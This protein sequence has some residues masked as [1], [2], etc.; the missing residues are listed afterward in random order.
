MATMIDILMPEDSQE[1]T[2]AN[3]G[4]W[5]AKVGDRV[6]QDDP[7]AE[8]ETD[9]VNVEVPAPAAGVLRE[10]LINEG[11]AVAPG[12]LLGRI[13]TGAAEPVSAPE[14]SPKSKP[15]PASAAAA[16]AA[17]AG[18]AERDASHLLSPSV[19][20][21]LAKHKLDRRLIKGTGRGGRI[22][23]RDAVQFLENKPAPVAAAAPSGAIP[24]RMVPH[25]KMR[26][27]IAAHMVES[28][29][30]TAPHVTAIF[31]MDLSSIIAH[32]KAHKA[33]FAKSGVNLTFTAYFVLASV[34]AIRAVP[35]VNSRFHADAL[36]IFDDMNIGVGTALGEKG[37]I[38]PVI[39]QAQRL[40]LFGVAEKLQ[41]LTQRAR[42]GKLAPREVQQGTFTISNH[43]VSGS[44]V[45][46]PIII[47]QPQSAILGVG[48]MQKRVIVVE[49]DG[50][51]SI[52]IRPMAY[53]TLSIDHR[54]LD[55]HQTNA[56]LSRFVA[57][58]EN[59]R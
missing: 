15:A 28:L 46:A 48:K 6:D 35:E 23:Y 25:D 40:N 50:Q 30:K 17:P 24:S 58:I 49:H 7:L 33:E 12:A 1:G 43:G 42:E 10:I 20:R 51:D 54:A 14:P 16:V 37:L 56:F 19:R 44:L 52:Q 29:L 39:H 47:N 34:E 8:I 45:A 53:V 9:K 32:R 5:L 22:T 4:R 31:E 21:L 57:V 11:G 41:E 27:S 38:V 36:E 3:L 2:E 59:W 13:E 18:P 55:A 26:R